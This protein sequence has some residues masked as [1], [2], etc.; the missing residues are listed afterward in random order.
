[1]G[2]GKIYYTREVVRDGPS[3]YDQQQQQQPRRHTDDEEE[4]V[5]IAIRREPEQLVP[6]PI[7]RG[8]PPAPATVW[9]RKVKSDLTRLYH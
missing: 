9:P 8:P 7:I 2:P 4:P 6:M 3:P 5:E 1:M